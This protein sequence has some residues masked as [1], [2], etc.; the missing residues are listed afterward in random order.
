MHV[1]PGTLRPLATSGFGRVFLAGMADDD[2]RQVVFRHNA[3]QTDD[4]S[5]LSLATVRR[6]VQAIRAAGHAVSID[7]VSPGAGV[8]ALLLPQP[9][10][11][12]PMAVGIGGSSPVIRA[13]F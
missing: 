2:V 12:T 4:G 13:W 8:V 5:R 9:S 3:Q 10:D 6:D 7:R 11:A 1:G